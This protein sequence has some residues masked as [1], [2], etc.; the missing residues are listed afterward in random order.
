MA[1]PYGEQRTYAVLPLKPMAFTVK[2][3]GLLYGLFRYLADNAK[4]RYDSPQMR[5]TPMVHGKHMVIGIGW[6]KAPE[7]GKKPSWHVL[8]HKS[9]L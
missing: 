5:G 9:G 1:V 6:F 3:T 4:L 2:H 8:D 7:H